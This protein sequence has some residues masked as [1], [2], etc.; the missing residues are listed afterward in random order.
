MPEYFG[1]LMLHGGCSEIRKSIQ[2]LV[3]TLFRGDPDN[4]VKYFGF[5]KVSGLLS[6]KGLLDKGSLAILRE[7]VMADM[8]PEEEEIEFLKVMDAIERLNRNGLI[9]IKKV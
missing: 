9:Q 5:G 4:L 2:E 8:N 7:P 6:A 3:F 1:I